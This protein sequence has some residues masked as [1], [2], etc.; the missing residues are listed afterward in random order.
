MAAEY[1][2]NTSIL[3]HQLMLTA[4]LQEFKNALMA[5]NGGLGLS[6]PAPK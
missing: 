3:E 1:P 5:A 6:L 4:Y 2:G